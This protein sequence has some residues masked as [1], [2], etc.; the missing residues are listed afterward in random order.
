VLASAFTVV[1]TIFLVAFAI[2]CVVIVTWA[3]RRDR[4][5]WRAW[6]ERQERR[7]G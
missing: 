3:L 4:A 5:G 1:F 2:L 6:R 7:D